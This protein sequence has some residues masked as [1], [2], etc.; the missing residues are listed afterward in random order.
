MAVVLAAGGVFWARPV[1]VFQQWTDLQMYFSGARSHWTTVDGYRMHYYVMG[2]ENG[3]AAVLVHGLGARAEDW[4]NLSPYLVRAGYRVY[5][6]DLPGYGQSEKPAD[7]SY[8][9]R[10]EAQVV[11]DFLNTLGLKQVDLGGWSMGGWIVQLVA[12][13]HPERIRRLMLFDSAGIYDRP[14][15]NTALFTPNNA[16]E[17]DQLDALLMPNPPK[18]PGFVSR[19][20]LRH[21]RKD[22]WV[23]QRA[24]AS[25]LTGKDTTD[26]LLPRLKMPVLL[27]WGAKDEITPL[28]QGEKMHLLVPQSEL[29]V[30]PGC[31]HLAPRQCT[32][33]IGPDVATFLLNR[34]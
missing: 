5:L 6:P 20:V 12:A 32:A 19:D 29:D 3:P 7:F 14:T 22:A 9:V 26:A 1:T 23:I 8:S 30:I 34:N 16:S 25:M 21:S 24:L 28:E 11:V 17:L 2:P 15:W 18:I 31:G 13:E 10:D 33:Q 4:Q 27:V